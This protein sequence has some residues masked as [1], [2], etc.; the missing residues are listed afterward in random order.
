MY[1]NIY[2]LYVKQSN[3]LVQ[4]SNQ[5][6]APEKFASLISLV[7]AHCSKPFAGSFGGLPDIRVGIAGADDS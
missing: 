7:R 5:Y 6:L 2:M 1:N 4:G 3:N